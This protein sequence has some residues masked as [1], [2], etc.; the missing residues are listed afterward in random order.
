MKDA[1]P[2]TMRYKRILL[3]DRGVF[4]IPHIGVRVV[5][6]IDAPKPIWRFS[7]HEIHL[8]ISAQDK[9]VACP[10]STDEGIY[11]LLN[12]DRVHAYITH[13]GLDDCVFLESWRRWTDCL[14][15]K[16]QSVIPADYPV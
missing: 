12:Q 11:C 5:P 13:P 10:I 2:D 1:V 7:W 16:C 8:K 6:G 15:D 14:Y 4:V 3:G 9:R